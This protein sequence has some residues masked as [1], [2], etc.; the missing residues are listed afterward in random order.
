M[1]AMVMP[2]EPGKTYEAIGPNVEHF[3]KAWKVQRVYIT[4]VTEKGYHT[5]APG[6]VAGIIAFGNEA[7]WREV[8]EDGSLA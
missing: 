6:Q 5:R 2:L 7:M 3:P 4:D 1:T 8:L